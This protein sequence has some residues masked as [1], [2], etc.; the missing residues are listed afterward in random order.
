MSV[1]LVPEDD[2]RAALRPYRVDPDAFE[3]AVRARLNASLSRV[4]N[5]IA[6]LSPAL[7]SA[8]AFLPLE[9]ITGGQMKGAAAKLAPATGV[10]KL[11]SYAAFPAIS[12]F[13]LLGATV[14]SVLKIRS[15]RHENGSEPLNEASLRARKNG[16]MTTSGAC[17]WYL[18]EPSPCRGSGRPGCYFWV[19][20]FLSGS[21][22]TF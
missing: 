16:G 2:L 20:S 14:F 19:T 9:I 15:I 11:L 17:R 5:P 10:Y 6:S 21:C 4:D 8:A 22:S 12:L 3:A 13:V 7:R 1:T 18:L